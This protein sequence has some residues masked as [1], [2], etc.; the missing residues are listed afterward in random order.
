[1]T[2]AE[3]REKRYSLAA[4]AMGVPYLLMSCPLRLYL[5]NSVIIIKVFVLFVD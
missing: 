3:P 5:T 2:A 1:V 4:L